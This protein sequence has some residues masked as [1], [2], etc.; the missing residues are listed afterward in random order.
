M[1]IVCHLLRGKSRAREAEAAVAA[2][3]VTHLLRH[4]RYLLTLKGRPPFRLAGIETYARLQGVVTLSQ[5]L[6]AQRPDLRLADLH[7]GLQPALAPWTLEYAELQQGAAWL[8]AIDHI[9]AAPEAA[10][11]TGAQVAQQLRTYLDDL[12][13]LPDL[14]PRLVAFRSHLGKVSTS[15]EPGLFHCYNIAD[16][17]RTNNG[18]ESHFRDTQRRLLRTTGPKGQMRR[19]LQRV[20]AWELLPRPLRKPNAWPRCAR[21]RGRSWPKSKLACASIRNVS[22]YRFDRSAASTLNLT[23]SVHSGARSRPSQ[24]GDFW[25][26]AIFQ[27]SL[28]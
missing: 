8:R 19:T 17:P 9:L 21:F 18:L 28:G 5:E 11:V 6:L 10:P 22:A 1:L 27:T 13:G 14:T 4:T 16:L 20:G 12:G 2:A 23:S 7:Q 24:R 25:A 3:V 26:I 15:Y